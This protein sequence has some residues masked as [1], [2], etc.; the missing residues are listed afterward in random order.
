M[1]RC[2]VVTFEDGSERRYEFAFDATLTV[3]WLEQTAPGSRFPVSESVALDG[4]SSVALAE[5]AA[6]PELREE[7][8]DLATF[9]VGAFDSPAPEG[10]PAPRRGRPPKA[11]G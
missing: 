10:N 2:L 6:P 8:A 3:A 9:A 5:V 11:K 1:P 7:L 4:V